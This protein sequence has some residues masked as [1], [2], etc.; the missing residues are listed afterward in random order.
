MGKSDSR[1][2]HLMCWKWRMV[3]YILDASSWVKT[4][5]SMVSAFLLM[6]AVHFLPLPYF[7]LQ[8]PLRQSSAEIGLV[9]IATIGYQK[10]TWILLAL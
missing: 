1:E 2:C 5:S 7:F 6:Q 8:N 4:R 9:L 10:I 3:L